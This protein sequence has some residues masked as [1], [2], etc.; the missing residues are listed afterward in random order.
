MYPTRR[1]LRTRIVLAFVA[2]GAALALLLASI[3]LGA[4]V[5]SERNTIE[6][7]VTAELAYLRN[8][9]EPHAAEIESISLFQGPAGEIRRRLPADLAPL[10]PGIHR[11][12]RPDRMV[13]VEEED[14]TLRVVSIDFAQLH[15]REHRLMTFL[16][17]AVL[18]AIYVSAWGGFWLSRK[19]IAPVRQLARSVTGRAAEGGEPLGPQH[20]DDEIGALAAAFDSHEARI[21]ELLERE[22]SFTDRTSHELRTPITVISGAAEL[23][24]ADPGLAPSQRQKVQRIQRATLEMAELVETFLLLAR[25]PEYVGAGTDREHASDSICR[26]A[27]RVVEDQRIW[28]EDKPVSLELDCVAD[29]SVPGAER[30]AAIVLANL[31]RNACQHTAEGSVTVRVM[32][33]C[34]EVLDTGPGM[35]SGDR[36]TASTRAPERR[37]LGMPLVRALCE[38]A[39]WTVAWSDRDGGGTIAR[40]CFATPDVDSSFTSG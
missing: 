39:G 30:L 8:S 34:V 7:L 38:R 12:E 35:G 2:F 26:L 3:V 37:G 15:A 19:I 11:L 29:A 10:S 24:L 23:L 18:L 6:D 27:R 32:A 31:V 28:L 16:A 40:V 4:F 13:G 33:G 5:Y 1:R 9:G 14:G 22:R 20:A 25:D 36:G 17:I 21:R